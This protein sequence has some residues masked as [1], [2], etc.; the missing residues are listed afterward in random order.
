ML[1]FFKM[2]SLRQ[3]YCAAVK[4]WSRAFFL[5][6][7]AEKCLL[8]DGRF[9]KS[10][11][12]EMS[13]AAHPP[14]LPWT[15]PRFCLCTVYRMYAAGTS[16]SKIVRGRYNHAHFFFCTFISLHYEIL[17]R[18]IAWVFFLSFFFVCFHASV[19]VLQEVVINAGNEWRFSK[20]P[21]T[22]PCC[23]RATCYYIVIIE[24]KTVYIRAK[25]PWKDSSHCCLLSL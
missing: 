18:H 17:F 21:R 12:G 19:Q 16:F 25:C 10:T 3:S 1:G 14:A 5:S 9:S 15:F 20:L 13:A 22:L 6:A 2:A 8:R 7:F 4:K 24:H 23:W 11:G